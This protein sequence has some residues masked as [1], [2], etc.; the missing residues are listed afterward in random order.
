MKMMCS[1]LRTLYRMASSI[2]ARAVDHVEQRAAVARGR[3]VGEEL[4]RDG[5]RPGGG[6]D[7]RRRDD[8]TVGPDRIVRRQRLAGV[9]VERRAFEVTAVDGSAQVRLVQDRSPRHVDDVRAA[10]QARENVP[11]DETARLGCQR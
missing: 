7:V 1:D 8:S 4:A 6:G 3:E 10:R 11:F 5:F 9:Y 2:A